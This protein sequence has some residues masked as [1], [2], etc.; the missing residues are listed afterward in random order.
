MQSGS[1]Q[2]KMIFELGLEA[3]YRLNFS[4]KRR[5]C[6]AEENSIVMINHV[7]GSKA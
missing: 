4:K 6:R 7:S 2:R 1:F 3:Y 5:E